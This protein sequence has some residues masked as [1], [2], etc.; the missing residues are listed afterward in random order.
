MFYKKQF[1]FQ[2][3]GHAIVYLVNEILKSF[4]NN[5]YTSGVFIDLTKAF[6]TVDHNILL[7]K[8]FHYG[9]RDNTLK[10]LQNYSHN[11]KQY[12]PYKNSSKT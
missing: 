2:K 9:I 12:I 5:C 7:K 3:Q 6:D 4:E 10:L 1:G 8:L 11:R